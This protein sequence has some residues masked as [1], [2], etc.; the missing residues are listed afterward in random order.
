VK[1]LTTR[2]CLAALAAFSLLGCEDDQP[3]TG[4]LPVGMAVVGSDYTSSVISLVDPATSAVVR[5]RCLDSGTRAPLLSATLSGDVTLP[6]EPQG[7]QQL[8]IIDRGNSTLTWLD[9]ASCQ[10]LRQMS[11]GDGF[12][13]NP[14]DVVAGPPGKAYVTRYNRNPGRADEGS[15][16]LVIDPAAAMALRT[17]PLPAPSTS[18]LPAGTLASARPTRALHI[19]GKL[20]VVLNNLSDDFA[21]GGPGRV[22]VV[23][24][25]SD[26]VT[27]TIE[28]PALKN[29]G[30]LARARN[31]AGRPAL[32]V[33]CDGLS[34]DG[35][36][37][38][39]SAGFAW[40]D[41]EPAPVVKVV[42]SQM[43]GRPVSGSV[44]AVAAP[45]LA[46]TVVAGDFMGPAT[47][48]VWG[49]DFAGGPPRK[50]VDGTGAFLLSVA[51][52]PDGQRLY[53]LDAA[54][55]QPRVRVYA[56]ATGGQMEETG[57]FVASP[58]T[59]LPPRVLGFY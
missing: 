7:D 41:L 31:A 35:T 5:D 59:G 18:E 22:A 15:D 2:A 50:L 24:T 19:G 28:I 3:L 48:A 56:R 58:E 12:G 14:Q 21:S 57:S 42:G 6:S 20:Y 51:L 40:V 25:T 49:F 17:I 16:L 23:D 44:L 33:G 13:A 53:V 1:D 55:A 46:F 34:S 38:L 10:V 8:L 29:C 54:P 30:A 26:S 9:P 45:D 47:D 39:D 27:S 36:A 4:G 32:V 37:R 43:F 52:S 11:A